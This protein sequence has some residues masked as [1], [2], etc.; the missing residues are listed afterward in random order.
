MQRGWRGTALVVIAALMGVLSGGTTPSAT[1]ATVSGRQ[2][3]SE[4]AAHV[5]APVVAQTATGATNEVTYGGGDLESVV[6][7]RVL[8]TRYGIG[9]PRVPLGASKTLTLKVTGTGGVPS[10]GVGAVVLNLTGISPTSATHLTVWPGGAARPAAS[11][12]NLAPGQVAPNLVVAGVGRGGV[13][14]LHNYAGSVDLVADVT[15]WFPEASGLQT[16]VPTRVLDTRSGLGAPRA[17]VGAGG[18]LTVELAGRAGI[19]ATGV[20]AVVVNLTGVA[21]TNNT[22]VTVWPAGATRPGTSTLNATRGVVTPNLAVATVGTGGRVSLYNQTGSIDL[23]ADVVAWF[24]SSAAYRATTPA[25]ILDTR[26]GLGAPA[27]LGPGAQVAVQVA[28]RGGVPTNGVGAVVLNLTGITPTRTTF[29]TAWPAGLPR[30]TASALNLVPGGVRANLVMLRLGSGGKVMLSNNA[31][32]THLA[33]DVVGWFPTGT[34]TSVAMIPAAGTTLHGASDLLGR[35]GDTRAGG[36]V[37]FAPSSDLPGVGGHFA[38]QGG[39]TSGPGVSGTVTGVSR[40]DDGSAVATFSPANLQDLFTSL[41]IRSVGTQSAAHPSA[42]SPGPSLT[43]SCENAGGVGLPLPSVSFA[44]LNGDADF[45]LTDG[46]ARFVLNGSLVLSWGIDVEAGGLCEVTLASGLLAWIGP[47]AVE[48]ELKA[49]LSISGK[50]KAQTMVTM[51]VRV[52]FT[53]AEGITTN[54]SSLDIDGTA[55]DEA[56]LAGSISASLTGAL[57]TQ[58]FGVVGVSGGLKP[59]ITASWTPGNPLGCVELKGGIAITL[60]AEAGRWGLSWT[61]NLA[62]VS[63]VETTLYTSSGCSAGHWVGTINVTNAAEF[64]DTTRGRTVKN[65]SGTYSN[66]QLQLDSAGRQ[67]Y[68]AQVVAS[69]NDQVFYPCPVTLGLFTTTTWSF[70]GSSDAAADGSGKP[71]TWYRGTAFELWN[72]PDG[73]YFMPYHVVFNGG[74]TTF[75]CAAYPAEPGFGSGSALSYSHVGLVEPTSPLVDTD[76][77]P[78]RLVGTTTLSEPPGGG[79]PHISYSY[80]ITYDLTFVPTTP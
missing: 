5:S 35:T 31:G 57:F 20:S 55:S 8:D 25:R 44:G 80:R 60:A 28:G 59:S 45:S 17:R 41:A 75:H 16:V 64:G 12:L 2:I 51:P 78:T 58:L 69:Y 7:S 33:G 22:F 39:P 56:T 70:S 65:V 40:R 19:P 24:P 49:T 23:V 9:A 50:L 71:L 29:I 76:P 79:T 32:T 6:P 68:K 74:W 3:A 61:W 42:A 53:H 38:V 14:N 36:T 34:G 48:W 63:V 1:A 77:S 30:P 46:S 26:L 21:P 18:V 37:T 62:E 11:S 27:G 10:S 67:S 4:P 54:L 52:G 47:I 66:L 13:V 43:G 72:R 15:G 73:T